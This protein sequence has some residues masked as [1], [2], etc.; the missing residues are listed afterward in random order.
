MTT[1]EN[2]PR[3]S[4]SARRSPFLRRHLLA[5]VLLAAAVVFILENTRKVHVRMFGPDVTAPLWEVLTATLVAG[6]LILGL[7]RRR[8]RANE[9]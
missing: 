1:Y 3:E 8:R 2:A 7:L 4:G 6:A 5:L 9:A